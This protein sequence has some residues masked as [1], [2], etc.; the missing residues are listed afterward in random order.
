MKTGQSLKQTAIQATH[1]V[2]ILSA[3]CQETEPRRMK[4]NAISTKSRS[5]KMETITTKLVAAGLLFLFTILSGVWLS[6]SGKPLNSVIFTI[7]KLIALATVILIVMSVYNLYKAL[8]LRTFVELAVI[9]ATGLLFL[10]LI[11]TGALLSRNVPLPGA[12]LRVHQVAPLLALV[13]SAI[14]V[15]LLA[16]GKS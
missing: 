16:S 5:M 2:K 10:A 11:I 15:Y 3:V 1:F 4:M 9:T 14:T 13:S 6:N 12:I 7:H 8:A